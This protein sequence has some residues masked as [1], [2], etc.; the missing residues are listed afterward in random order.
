METQKA[1]LEHDLT[2]KQAELEN[3][4][5]LSEQEKETLRQEINHQTN[6]IRAK[7]N[8]IALENASGK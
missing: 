2:Q 8:E 4:Q 5:K 1:N 7:E 6:Q 3:N